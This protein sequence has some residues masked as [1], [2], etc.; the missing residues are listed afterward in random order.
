MFLVFDNYQG[1]YYTS[2]YNVYKMFYHRILGIT[3]T[4]F[5]FSDSFLIS[6]LSSL[7]QRPSVVYFIIMVVRTEWVR[8]Q[9]VFV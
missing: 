4:I 3:K 2:M 9:N 5:I 8:I 6:V 1:K 7:S